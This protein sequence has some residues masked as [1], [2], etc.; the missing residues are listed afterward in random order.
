MKKIIIEIYYRGNKKDQ[1]VLKARS[2]KQAKEI[3]DSLLKECVLL[4]NIYGN[5]YNIVCKKIQK[6]NLK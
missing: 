1:I 6:G 4:S 2:K 3:I 5:D